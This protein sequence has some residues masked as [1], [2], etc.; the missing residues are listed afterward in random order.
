MTPPA[1]AAA[2][3]AKRRA[4]SPRQATVRH[5]RRISGP[6]RP[7]RS[8][9]A[10]VAMPSPGIALPRRRPLAP[11]RSR[12]SRKPTR[13]SSQAPGIAL[14]A[15]DALEGISSN[16]LLDRLIR[17]RIWIGLLAF[18]LIGIVAMQLLVLKLNTGIGHTITR[19][20][21]LERQNAQLNVEN[22]MSSGEN[23]IEPLAAAAGMTLAPAGTVHFVAAAQSDVA[24]A[25]AALSTAVQAPVSSASETAG[26]EIATGSQT[27]SQS[28]AATGES[29]GSSE[30][31]SASPTV[32]E[33]PSGT[34]ESPSSSA[35][36]QGTTTPSSSPS[37][38][39]VTPSSAAGTQPTGASAA[40][41]SET[42]TAGTA[43]SGPGGGTQAA[44]QE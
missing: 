8:T 26:S 35:V 28:T 13:G 24:R 21:M 12:P 41:S 36:S 34:S 44:S 7:P 11:V 38:P 6:A 43:A 10:A 22:S 4:P 16:A 19:A 2:R 39:S 29:S 27:E 3:P 30:T 42:A 5:P 14:R 32:G 31:T 33:T 23:L 15:I 25:A 17:G 18:A 1:T 40:P 20:A 9:A 37:T